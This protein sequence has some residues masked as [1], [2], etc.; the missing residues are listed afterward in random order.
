M[1]EKMDK[2]TACHMLA[3]INEAIYECENNIEQIDN[4]LCWDSKNR[5]WLLNKKE[6]A[7]L[8]LDELHAEH[9]EFLSNYSDIIYS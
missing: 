1:S 4:R 7:L 5:E 2:K 8:R 6:N 9:D 3:D